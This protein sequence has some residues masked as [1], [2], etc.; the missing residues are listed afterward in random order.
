VRSSC[1]EIANGGCGLA[2]GAVEIEHEVSGRAAIPRVTKKRIPK[3]ER[4]STAQK[5]EKTALRGGCDSALMRCARPPL[6]RRRMGPLPAAGIRGNRERYSREAYFRPAS[7]TTF[8][9]GQKVTCTFVCNGGAPGPAC[10]MP[11]EWF[12]CRGLL[13]IAEGSEWSATI[14]PVAWAE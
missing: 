7:F 8:L 14:D 9:Q 3:S 10:Q 4:E 6:H 5:A 13:K 12:S 11:S 2:R 1:S